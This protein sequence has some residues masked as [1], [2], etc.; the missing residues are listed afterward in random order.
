M[1]EQWGKPAN[2]RSNQAKLHLGISPQ[3]GLLQRAQP[4]LPPGG[5]A[6]LLTCCLSHL[7][8]AIVSDFRVN[9]SCKPDFSPALRHVLWHGFDT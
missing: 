2:V 1:K 6:V 3:H 5:H 9:R 8:I 4:A 7:P